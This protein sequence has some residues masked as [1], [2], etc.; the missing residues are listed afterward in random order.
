M[1][2]PLLPHT[3]G[4]LAVVSYIV[5]LLPTILRI[6]FPRLKSTGI[7]QILLKQRRQIGIL[8]FAL[9]SG[10]S[11]LLI[12]QRDIDWLDLKT[13]WIYFQGLT[14]FAIFLILTLTSNDWSIKKLKKNWKQLH[15]L[16]YLAMFLLPW[17]IWDKMSG[18]WTYL[19]PF[20]IIALTT[21]TVLFLIRLGIEFR[22]KQQKNRKNAEETQS[23]LKSA[24]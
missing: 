17:H 18:K 16:T 12:Q 6:V 13:S 3:L 2:Q 15:K 4:F 10:H 19:T 5:T 21:I 9:A 14:T 23:L 24:K 11:F 7:L 1:D 8:A 22:Q 20:G